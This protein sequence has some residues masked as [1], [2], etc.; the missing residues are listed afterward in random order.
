VIKNIYLLTEEL[1][2]TTEK[3]NINQTNL[4]QLIKP[5][6]IFSL[7]VFSLL[8]PPS[9]FSLGSGEGGGGPG[10]SRV[11]LAWRAPD[12]TKNNTHNVK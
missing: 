3:A 8:S 4:S 6:F 7:P 9:G 10:E 1:C 12:H 11:G 2:E 5:M